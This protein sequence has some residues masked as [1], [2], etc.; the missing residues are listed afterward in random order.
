MK[1]DEGMFLLNAVLL[2]ALAD[3]HRITKKIIEAVPSGRADYRPH[4]VARTALELARH[5]VEIEMLLVNGAA[6][7]EIN[8]SVARTG[9]LHQ[10]PEL[11][12]WY[13]TAFSVSFG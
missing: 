3:E 13:S 6:S 11:A 4:P 2:P 9:D 12:A 10:I 8:R 5:T 1:P 7:G